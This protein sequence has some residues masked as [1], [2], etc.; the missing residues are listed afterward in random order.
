MSRKETDSLSISRYATRILYLQLKYGAE[1]DTGC[2]Q[3]LPESVAYILQQS[4]LPDY[5]GQTVDQY[6]S[7]IESSCEYWL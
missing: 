1:D 4:Q 3:R 7:S 6:L 5:N 2:V